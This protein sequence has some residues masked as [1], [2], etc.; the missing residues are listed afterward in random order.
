MN[1]QAMMQQAKK[2]QKE[3]MDAKESIYKKE[4]ICQKSFVTV[5]AF[6]NKKIKEV[7]IDS[8]NLEKEDIEMLQDLILVATNDVMDQIDK[9]TEKV[10]GKYTQGMPGLF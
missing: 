4:F 1:I 8:E 6:G 10:M 3:M 2:M 9:E 7:K 5:V